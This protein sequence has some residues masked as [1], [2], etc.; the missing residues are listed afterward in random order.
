MKGS[1]LVNLRILK[2]PRATAAFEAAE[3]AN[4]PYG[5]FLVQRCFVELSQLMEAMEHKAREALF[6]CYA[7]ESGEA[8]F[9]PGL[10]LP[11][12]A[13]GLRLPLGP[14]HRDAVAR[15]RE[16]TMFREIFPRLDTTFRVLRKFA[17]ETFS[18]EDVLL[19][20]ADAPGASRTPLTPL[21]RLS[22]RECRRLSME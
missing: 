19:D 8:E 13:V 4:L 5:T 9:T 6:D 18:E 20:L 11:A 15:L 17:V 22:E 7:W 14:Q 10:P 16:W 1:V 21:L 12:R 2:A 3:G